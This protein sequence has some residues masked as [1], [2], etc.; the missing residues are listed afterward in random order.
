MTKTEK[1][2]LEVAAYVDIFSAWKHAWENVKGKGYVMGKRSLN[3]AKKLEEKGILCVFNEDH[4]NNSASY[5]VKNHTLLRQNMDESTYND[6][7]DSARTNGENKSN[8]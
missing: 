1:E 6:I 8:R 3:A 5:I 7:R 2:I 4:K